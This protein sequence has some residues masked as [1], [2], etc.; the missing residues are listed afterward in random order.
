[1]P[2]VNHKVFSYHSV[3]QSSFTDQ[4]SRI[5]RDDEELAKLEA[6]RRPGR[7]TSSQYDRLKLRKKGEEMEYESGYW[8]PE[9]ADQGNL[10]KLRE[11][12]GTWASL[13]TIKFVRVS[14]NGNTMESTFPP[15]GL[16]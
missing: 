13:A 11:W 10:E 16:S 7:P 3:L 15:K 1:M 4:D 8:L 14:A 12:D 6:E 5:G 9:L 2:G